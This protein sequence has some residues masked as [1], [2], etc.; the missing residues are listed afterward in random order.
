MKLKKSNVVVFIMFFKSLFLLNCS[1]IEKHNAQIDKK[2][3]PFLLKKDLLFVKKKLDKHHPNLDWYITK[4]SLNYLFTNLE[5]E[6]E[7]PLK[8]NEFYLKLS[9]IISSIRQGHTR[10][11]PLFKRI[12]KK[13]NNR[14]KDKGTGPLSQ[15][16]FIF[17]NDSLYISK[18]KSPDSTIQK[19]T[20][21]LKI[22]DLCPTELYYKYRKTVSSDGFNETYYRHWF[23]RSFGT[24]FTLEKGILDTINFQLKYKDSVFEYKTIRLEKEKKKDVKKDTLK[25]K[26]TDPQLSKN[27]K[28]KKKIFGWANNRLAKELIISK[29][30]SS[31]AILHIRSFSQGKHKKAY[32][33]IFNEIQNKN[34]QHLIIDLRNNPGGRIIDN[35]N[36]Y[37]YLV[38]KPFVMNKKSVVTSKASTI[39]PMLNHSP[40]WLYPVAIFG[41]P[42]FTSYQWISTN[43]NKDGK[44]TYHTAGSQLKMPNKLNFKEK[45]YVLINGGSFSASSIFSAKLKADKRALFFGEET[46]G[47]FNGT[48][49]GLNLGYKLRHSKL[50][51][52]L[53][54]MDIRMLDEIGE[55]GR[56]VMPDI[57]LKPSLEK[58]LDTEDMDLKE[59][60]NY[61]KSA[62]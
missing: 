15:F 59:V 41:Y 55:H 57:E 18:N 44:L 52:R 25:I 14:L 8:P 54:I 27:L 17:F 19:G 9:P 5:N 36:L 2:I 4:D 24:Y 7:Q 32:H 51:L 6:L 47:A 34:I 1:S 3:D 21:V 38:D 43:K 56:G 42:F 23:N 37:S 28:K 53:W 31:I 62:P 20:K 12:S 48:V 11:S 16:D 61:I 39:A 40:K 33:Q 22:N 46:G 29:K 30:D 58:F 10:L 13:E 50:G 26:K 45:V 35:V 60:I 49:A